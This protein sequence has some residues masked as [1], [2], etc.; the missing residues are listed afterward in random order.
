MFGSLKHIF[1][2][3]LG[4]AV[5]FIL[6]LVTYHLT[7]TTAMLEIN[8]ILVM[9]YALISM[10]AHRTW[11]HNRS[12]S[13]QSIV[14]VSSI[15]DL[16]VLTA[17]LYLN[18]GSHN[19]FTILYVPLT[20][21]AAMY[22]DQKR[23][24][25]IC[26]GALAGLYGVFHTGTLSDEHAQH[27]TPG[28]DYLAH[29]NGMWL[30]NSIAVIVISYF[31]STLRSAQERA[32][33]KNRQLQD[34]LFQV[35]RIESLGRLMA[36][37]A[38]KLNTPLASL[39]LGL[40][41]LQNRKNPLSEKERGVWYEDM[42]KALD[43]A[44]SLFQSVKSND[45]EN[46]E[47][48]QQSQNMA[49]YFTVQIGRWQGLRR[50]HVD[51][52]MNTGNLTAPLRFCHDLFAIVEALFDNAIDAKRED[53]IIIIKFSMI[54]L[55]KKLSVQI[56]D[57]G[58]GMSDEVLRFAVDP[59]FTTKKRGTGLGLYNAH[60]WAKNSGGALLLESAEGK[61]TV[62]TIKIPLGACV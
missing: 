7:V 55:E 38:H 27:M 33:V 28:A 57:N 59:L 12:S 39:R 10:R 43:Q 32:V 21:V 62:V 61:G 6:V 31:I 2:F 42:S 19:P 37:T 34:T 36:S 56:T 60:Q 35:E 44:Q 41:E 23:L 40:S 25:V 20:A 17:L 24:I 51:V 30:A 8:L 3:R 22:L 4:L 58:A 18:G 45:W 47:E 49:D 50:V 29:L 9:L 11:K 1:L 16:V 5:F 48:L 15:V 14:F 54:I 13:V 26:L 53:E 46:G 52:L